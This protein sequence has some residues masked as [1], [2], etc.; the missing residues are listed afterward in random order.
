MAFKQWTAATLLACAAGAHAYEPQAGTWVVSS[1]VDGRPGRGLSV[2]VQNGTLAL[3]MYAYESSGQ[4]TFYLAVGPVADNKVT[5]RL[6]R[7]TG[8][9]FFGSG[10]QSG[11]EAQSPGNVTVRFTS[12]TT[13]FITF[14][15][16]PEKPIS[17]FS[18]G[19]PRV[20][21]SLAGYWTFTSFGNEGMRADV[22]QLT[23][24][25][26]GTANGNGLMVSSDGLFG[27]EH[28]TSGTLSGNV[29]CVRVSSGGTLQ[30][31]YLMSYS[32]N[33]GEGYSQTAGT[34]AQ[35]FLVVRR[36]ATARGDGTGIV[37]K[38]SDDNAALPVPESAL[39]TLRA[40]LAQ[41]A[42]EESAAP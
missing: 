9:R 11:T 35:Q 15:N 41:V 14:P 18:F 10:A 4:P 30:R 42:A 34:G 7:Y 5:A 21:A 31:S 36:V 8:G 20:P 25:G 23:T 28:Q 33:D 2:D 37:Y 19:Y 32:V 38:A 22:V 6:N 24:P 40:H 12:G 26:A 27:C 16:E 17:R 29:V 1:E 13:G 3:Q 39:Q